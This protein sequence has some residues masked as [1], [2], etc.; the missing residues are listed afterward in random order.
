MEQDERRSDVRGDLSF[1]V[2][3]ETLSR[4]EYEE[5][6]LH[7]GKIFSRSLSDLSFN[8]GQSTETGRSEMDAFFLKYLL[9]LD[10]KL[11]RILSLLL[12]ERKKE[13]SVLDG[14]G[15]DISGSGMKFCS[16]HSLVLGQIV[17][18]KLFL[19]NPPFTFVDV[20]GEVIWINP[21]DHDGATLYHIGLRF[22]ELSSAHK[23]NIVNF[24]FK[25][26]REAIRRMRS[27]G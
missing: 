20:F 16:D 15:L 18:A 1:P 24:V 9:Q 4:K 26:Q 2:K 22:L 21:V 12:G 14:V 17:H 5:R 25:K 27:A 23:E 10:E 13:K 6:K 3:I 7:Q 11:E 19:S 8:L